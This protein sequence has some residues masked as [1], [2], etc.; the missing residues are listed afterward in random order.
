MSDLVNGMHETL[1]HIRRVQELLGV[2]VQNLLYRARVH[3]TSKL[4]EPEASVFAKYGPM[5]KE[6]TYGSQKYKE[7]LKQMQPALEHHYRQNRHHPEYW[8]GSGIANMSLLD[9]IE[10]I[11]DWKAASERHDNG[12][13]N[14]SITLN[15]ERFGYGDELAAILRRT[16]GEL[17]P[18]HRE[19][20][21]CFCC[22]AGGCEGN[23]CERCGAGRD[24]YKVKRGD[25]DE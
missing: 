25:S 8:Q 4:S 13:I 23:F 7:C 17:F 18:K 20:W 3:D 16:V 24:D 19:P 5:L 9:L 2:V 11:V 1:Q 10:M 6:I 21:H 12:D 22:G 15:Q 14:K